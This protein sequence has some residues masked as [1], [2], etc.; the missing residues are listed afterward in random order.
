MVWSYGHDTQTLAVGTT[1]GSGDAKTNAKFGPLNWD[2]FSRDVTVASHFSQTVGVYNLEGCVRQGFL[3]RLITMDWNQGRDC[4][5][6]SPCE[7]AEVSPSG[8]KPFFGRRLM[9]ST[10]WRSF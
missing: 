6:R 9:R 2:E 8:C 10:S 4:T 3:P 1:L 5:G 7:S